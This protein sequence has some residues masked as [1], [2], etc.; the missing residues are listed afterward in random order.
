MSR[1]IS[2]ASL[3]ER[4]KNGRPYHVKPGENTRGSLEEFEQPN[5]KPS[6]VAQTQRSFWMLQNQNERNYFG[7]SKQT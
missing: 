5:R 3:Y 2:F 1:S 4:N 6:L 7:Q